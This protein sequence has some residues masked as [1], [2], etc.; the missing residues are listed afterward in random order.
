[1]KLK[2]KSAKNYMTFSF[3]LKCRSGQLHRQPTAYVLQ[4]FKHFMMSKVS[5]LPLPVKKKQ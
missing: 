1:M 4:C 2:Q 3:F 5:K